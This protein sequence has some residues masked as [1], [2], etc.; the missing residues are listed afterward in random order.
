MIEKGHIN[1][2]KILLALDITIINTKFHGLPILGLA[3]LRD[4]IELVKLLLSNEADFIVQD[5][6]GWTALMI[7]TVNKRTEIIKLLKKVGA[8]K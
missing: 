7:A 6:K 5:D 2:F 8:R 4:N 1:N 3:I